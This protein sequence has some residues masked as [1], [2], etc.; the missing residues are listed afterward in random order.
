MHTHLI[1]PILMNIPLC[2]PLSHW[3]LSFTLCVHLFQTKLCLYLQIKCC[4]RF[5]SHP[6]VCLLT[7]P[8]YLWYRPLHPCYTTAASMPASA[9]S[10]G[11]QGRVAFLSISILITFR[12][13]TS[14]WTQIKKCTC[15]QMLLLFLVEM[16]KWVSPLWWWQV[17]HFEKR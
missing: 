2:H 11:T 13:K 10:C 4:T 5:L 16:P 12:R 14:R 17:N 9:R 6:Y 1:P 15:W 7:S 3:S 8:L